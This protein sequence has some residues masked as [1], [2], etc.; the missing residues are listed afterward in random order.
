[1]RRTTPEERMF[2]YEDKHDQMIGSKFQ[3]YVNECLIETHGK[4]EDPAKYPIR[5]D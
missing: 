3:A 1:M 5:M 2:L 4:L